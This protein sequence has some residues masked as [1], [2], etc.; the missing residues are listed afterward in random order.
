MDRHISRVKESGQ[1]AHPFHLRF[2]F[3]LTSLP[4]GL[5][6]E[7]MDAAEPSYAHYKFFNKPSIQSV[8]AFTLRSPIN[9]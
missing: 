3:L 2:T 8:L 1:N 9:G 5:L 6:I 7:V 4:G